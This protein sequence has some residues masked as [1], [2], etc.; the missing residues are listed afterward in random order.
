MERKLKN[1]GTNID[2][3]I[4]ITIRTAKGPVIVDSENKTL[5]FD[6]Q[7]SGALIMF[8]PLQ[9]AAS[10]DR[11]GIITHPVIWIKD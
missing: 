7:E 5:I 10:V 2:N 8:L 11:V 6:A 4:R 3:R 1:L 9:I